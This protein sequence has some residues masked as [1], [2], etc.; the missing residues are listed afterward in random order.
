MVRNRF[1]FGS[2]LIRFWFDFVPIRNVGVE[3]FAR[4][5]RKRFGFDPVSVRFWFTWISN[6]ETADDGE[7][8]R[9]GINTEFAE[10]TESTELES[11]SGGKLDD[12]RIRRTRGAGKKLAG[13]GGTTGVFGGLAICWDRE[14]HELREKGSGLVFWTSDDEFSLL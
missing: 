13:T 11:K 1:G 7:K 2:L 8:R 9:E 3:R 4:A 14:R 10:G 5:V 12:R 6:A